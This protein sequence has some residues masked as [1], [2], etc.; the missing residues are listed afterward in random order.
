MN[1]TD[2]IEIK[3]RRMKTNKK[4]KKIYLKHDPAFKPSYIK[5]KISIS[6]NLP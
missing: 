4:G 5:M 2:N 6:I 1:I 3:K